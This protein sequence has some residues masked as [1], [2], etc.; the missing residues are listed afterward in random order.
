M[1]STEATVIAGG[2]LGRATMITGTPSSRAAEVEFILE[3]L[4]L[5]K[6]LNKYAVSGRSTYTG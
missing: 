1:S 6:M 4:H 3:G 2:F 5:N